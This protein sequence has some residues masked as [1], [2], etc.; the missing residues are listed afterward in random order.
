MEPSAGRIA[1]L[2]QH[3]PILHRSTPVTLHSH[4]HSLSTQVQDT[5]AGNEQMGIFSTQMGSLQGVLSSLASE[6][7]EIKVVTCRGRDKS[8]MGTG[9]LMHERPYVVAPDGC[10]C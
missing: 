2:T 5:V 9:L 4:P 3:V 7:A 10:L 8:G 1:L 6:I